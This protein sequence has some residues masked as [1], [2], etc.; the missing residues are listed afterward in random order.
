MTADF[1][2]GGDDMT[3]GGS[4]GTVEDDAGMK[5]NTDSGLPQLQEVDDAGAHSAG[6]GAQ[7][8]PQQS[9]EEGYT[10]RQTQKSTGQD[11]ANLGSG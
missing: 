4:A 10:A 3:G 11:P 5:V 9:A 2:A 7:R 1:S 6:F 8:D